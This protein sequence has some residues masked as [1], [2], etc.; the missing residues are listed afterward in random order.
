MPS[1]QIPD[2]M[3]G[4]ASVFP[5]KPLF[6]SLLAAFDPAAT[7]IGVAWG[8]LAVVALWGAAGVVLALRLFRWAPH[9]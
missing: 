4:I 5:V 6:D 1:D 3:D 9:R 7:G 8:D 2:W